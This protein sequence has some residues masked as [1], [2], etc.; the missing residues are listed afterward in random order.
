[1]RDSKS[2]AALQHRKI[3]PY[4]TKFVSMKTRGRR[5]RARRIGR[6]MPCPTTIRP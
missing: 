2:D 1:M 6:A 4:E 3:S 5:P